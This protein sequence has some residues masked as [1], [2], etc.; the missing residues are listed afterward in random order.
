MNHQVNLHIFGVFFINVKTAV[1][2]LKQAG[3]SC[4]LQILIWIYKICVTFEINLLMWNT[5]QGYIF[6]EIKFGNTQNPA[7]ISTDLAD[8]YKYLE[9][10]H[11]EIEQI[12]LRTGGRGQN[13][14]FFNSKSSK[15]FGRL[16]IFLLI[17]IVVAGGIIYFS[18]FRLYGELIA[19][20]IDFDW[21]KVLNIVSRNEKQEI[22]INA[23]QCL[24]NQEY[25]LYGCLV[26]LGTDNLVGQYW[27]TKYK[28]YATAVRADE[29]YLQL[30]S[31]LREYEDIRRRRH[32]RDEAIAAL[33][34]EIKL[35]NAIKRWINFGIGLPSVLFQLYALTKAVKDENIVNA[36]FAISGFISNGCTVFNHLLEKPRS[37]PILDGINMLLH[38]S[39]LILAIDKLD[40]HQIFLSL[41]DLERDLQ[42]KSEVSILKRFIEDVTA[43]SVGAIMAACFCISIFG[44]PPGGGG[45]IF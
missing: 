41:F 33:N 23:A 37:L 32:A 16:Y 11:K 9:L 15:N 13:K 25:Q 31:L 6:P 43:F 10:L 19:L 2:V 24:A 42:R 3:N 20:K 21:S 34:S 28:D 17:L 5:D 35:A 45:L 8:V 39:E 44:Y 4:Y 12:N 1:K 7:Y 27:V 38:S 40:F 36:T 29:L 22:L 26:H 30:E 14:S 18:F